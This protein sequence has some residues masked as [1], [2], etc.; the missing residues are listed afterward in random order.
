MPVRAGA[1]DSDGVSIHYLDWEAP[2]PGAPPLVLL[3]AT[4]FL[5]VMWRPIADRLAAR[6][7]VIA[8]DQRG[9]GDSGKPPDGYTFEVFADDL[10]RLIDALGLER[11]LV[12][13]HSS[14]ATT[15]VTH[16]ARFPGVLGR[17]VLIEPIL[18]RPDWFS[19]IPPG[20]RSSMSLADGARK[21]RAVWS[22][23]EEALASYRTKDMFRGW[24]Q[25]VLRA[26]VDEGMSDRDDG[27][28]ELKCP[29]PIEGRFFDAVRDVDAWAMLPKLSC[30]VLFLW[31]AE[32]HLHGRGLDAAAQDAL[33]H[34][35]TVIVPGTTHFLPQER[36]DEVARLMVGFLGD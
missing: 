24:D 36:P 4:G 20:G 35:S 18:P 9:H 6:F 32:S 30:P 33:P 23:R 15:I 8:V 14:G 17:V 5:A 29:P 10:Q 34:A 16:A 3:H 21:R 2:A 26:Y 19:N 28:V 27:Q 22:S 11:P 13:G 1:V 31:G 7:R 12:A 25:D